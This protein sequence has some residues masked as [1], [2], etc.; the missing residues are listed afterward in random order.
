MATGIRI[1]D[2]R[3]GRLTTKDTPNNDWQ[4]RS[5]N[6]E[7]DRYT[8]S[9]LERRAAHADDLSTRRTAR[10]SSFYPDRSARPRRVRRRR[11]CR[12]R[13]VGPAVGQSDLAPRGGQR[14][15][16]RARASRLR[17]LAE[18]TDGLAI[19]GTNDIDEGLQANH[20]RPELVLP[21]R[22]LLDR[23]AGRE[24]SLDHGPRE[25]SGRRGPRAARVS[26]AERGRR[27]RAR[28]PDSRRRRRCRRR[29]R[30]LPTAASAA[31]AKI[32]SRGRAI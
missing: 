28:S 19:V 22:V 21:A 13:G 8:L 5:A 18:G 4:A 29:E 6:C 27:R 16:V 12:R 9:E 1:I 24:V 25:A 32:A 26:G 17:R 15:R 3:N 14:A 7:A 23:Q 2:P 20:R 31:V 11:S 30:R 10:T